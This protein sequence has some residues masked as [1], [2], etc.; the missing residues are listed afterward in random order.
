MKC[1]EKKGFYSMVHHSPLHSD[2]MDDLYLAISN[3]QD[4]DECYRF[5]EDI[6]SESELLAIAQRWHVAKMLNEGATY[7][8]ISEKLNASTA[9]ISRINRSLIYGTGGYRMLLDRLEALRHMEALHEAEAPGKFDGAYE[10]TEARD[11]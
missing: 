7:Q 10:Q 3:L 6:C 11:D 1:T 8:L 5:F 2:E 9:T 4:V